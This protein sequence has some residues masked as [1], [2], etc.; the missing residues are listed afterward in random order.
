M[1]M[2][3]RAFPVDHLVRAIS[4]VRS[5]KSYGTSPRTLSRSAA[6]VDEETEGEGYYTFSAYELYYQLALMLS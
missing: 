4:Y 2:V 6:P 3:N 5:L 1:R